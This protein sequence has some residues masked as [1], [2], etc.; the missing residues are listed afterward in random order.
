MIWRVGDGKSIQIQKAHWLPRSEGRKAASFVRRTRIQWVNQLILPNERH[1]NVELIN[2]IFYHFDAEEICKLRIPSVATE[3]SIA[4]HYEKSGQFTV[5]S[6]YKLADMIKRNTTSGA[7][8]SNSEVGVR[9]LWDIIW[10]ARVPE[11][12][13]IFG[14]R[15]AANSLATKQNTCR[16]TITTDNV[17]SL[18]GCEEEDEFHAVSACTRSKALRFTMRPAWNLPKEEKFRHNGKDWLQI[19]LSSQNEITRRRILM[20]F[21]QCWN[22]RNNAIHGDGKDTVQG[23]ALFLTR[24]EEEFA[25]AQIPEKPDGKSSYSLRQLGSDTG[26][27]P[28]ATKWL[29]PEE[30]WAK[31]NTDASFLQASGDSWGGAVARDFH[32]RVLLSACLD[33]GKCKLPNRGRSCCCS[34]GSERAG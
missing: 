7:S 19:L 32:G 10:K 17:C 8:S 31:L 30:G 3:D 1:W 28:N 4:W 14:W 26:A 29:A 15:V 13:K 33:M 24:Y 9:N 23:S 5:K 21:W 20:L 27:D 22:L 16:R 18:C 11:K 12:I 6:A 34:G 25:T 2:Q